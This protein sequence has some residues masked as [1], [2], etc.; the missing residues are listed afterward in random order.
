MVCGSQRCRPGLLGI[1]LLA[2]LAALAVLAGCDRGEQEPSAVGTTKAASAGATTPAGTTKPGSA[3]TVASPD[4]VYEF[5]VRS[6]SAH[7]GRAHHDYPATDLFAPCGS[8][9]VAPTDGRVAEVSRTDHWSSRQNDGATRGGLSV[10]IVGSDGVRYY[11]SHLRSIAASIVPG[12][13]VRAGDVL[14]RV[15]NTGDAR[16]VACHLHFG[17]SPV[18]GTKDWWNRRGVLSPYSFLKSWQVGGQRS[19]VRAVAAWKA[20]RGC[21]ASPTVDP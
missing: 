7:F 16:S 18:C 6:R 20:K 1:Q 10:L 19:P 17:I 21:P 13:P 11:G 12:R 15:G 2:M 8:S 5:P 14:G 9:V 4:P 3:A